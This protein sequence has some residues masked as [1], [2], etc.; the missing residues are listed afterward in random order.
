M[1]FI[2][3]VKNFIDEYGMFDG[4]NDVI[5][6]VSGG[7]DSTALLL[8]LNEL[9]DIY[10]FKIH[11][12]HVNH[13]IRGEE[14]DRDEQFVRNLSEKLGLSIHVFK[15]DVPRISKEMSLTEEEAG[16]I[17][18]YDAF[19]EVM[20]EI[21]KDGNRRACIAV[22]HNRDDLAETV[23]FNIIRGS[24]LRGIGGMRPKRDRII[25]PLL[26]TWRSDIEAYLSSESQDYVTDSTN[27]MTEYSRNRLRNVIIPEMMA[28]NSGSKEHISALALDTWK[29]Y[30]S[31]DE[32]V[33]SL[34]IGKKDA[35]GNV[36]LDIEE[37]SM[38]DAFTRNELFIAALGSV[39]GKRKD[40]TRRHIEAVSGLIHS[41]SGRKVSLPYGITA[42]RSYDR[43][44]I[45]R[46]EDGNEE[47][48]AAELSER[49]MIE[50]MPGDSFSGISKETYTKMV[51]CDKIGGI[52]RVRYPEENDYI[53][54]NGDGGTKK[55]KRLFTDLKI[56][57]N[58]RKSVPVVAVGDTNEIIWVVGYRLSEAFK[59]DENTKRIYIMKFL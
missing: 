40:I 16:R 44:I 1:D 55:L 19:D 17:I 22:A 46:F 49:F 35:D 38:L 52:P 8:L 50:E 47:V 59:I 25:R 58:K 26:M 37:I 31:I 20:K 10:S 13:M 56:D 32:R 36:T 51:D 18:R 7:A 5:A 54:I 29:L 24:S 6:G 42:M 27:L 11:V 43:L 41:E 21:T 45:T 28:V 12:V 4:V 23:L 34:L 2:R 15:K 33:E 30:D 39:G 53:V 9:R 3:N 48:S 14:A 57:R